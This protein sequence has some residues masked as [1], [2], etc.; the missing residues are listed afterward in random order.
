MQILL[1]S[2]PGTGAIWY[3][4]PAPSQTTIESLDSR[5]LEP[6][7]GGPVLQA[8]EFRAN[9]PGAYRLTFQLKREWEGVVRR[10]RHVVVS[11]ER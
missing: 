6:G 7:I 1:E 10:E 9:A 3:A 8:F 5:R 2:M 11:I 4:P